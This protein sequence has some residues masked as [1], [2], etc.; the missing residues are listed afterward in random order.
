ML[1]ASDNII[2]S[3]T[4][5]Q[6][7]DPLGLLLFWMAVDGV[8]RSIASPFNIWYIGD[9]TLGGSIEAVAADLRRVIS[10]LSLLGLGINSSK[11]EIINL[12]YSADDFESAIR[13]I[14]LILEDIKIT[15]NEELHILGSSVFPMVIRECLDTKHIILTRM[16]EKLQLIDANPALF[17]LKNS[18]SLPSFLYTLLSAPCYLEQDFLNDMDITVKRC[19]ELIC[20][21]NIDDIDWRQAKLPLSFGGLGLRSAA[22]L[23][24]PTYLSSLSFSCKLIDEILNVF[25]VFFFEP[26]SSAWAQELRSLW[27]SIASPVCYLLHNREV[28][29][30]SLDVDPCFPQCKPSKFAAIIGISASLSIISVF[31]DFRFT[32]R[33][34]YSTR[35][36]SNFARNASFLAAFRKAP[37]LCCSTSLRFLIKLVI[38]IYLSIYLSI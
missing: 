33:C 38:S 19:K 28:A 27:I 35:S 20:N 5:I 32:S 8:A 15:S 36:T 14:R 6:Q 18:F 12:N 29:P 37:C 2:S 24:L 26:A 16:T 7:G 1:I 31:P 13:D 30:S 3:A 25:R 23:A 22:D 4:G 9:A 34:H 11:S 21:V 17:L 10:A